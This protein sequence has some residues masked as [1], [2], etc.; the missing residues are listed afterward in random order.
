MFP[1]IWQRNK[2]TLTVRQLVIQS[3]ITGESYKGEGRVSEKP[4]MSVS[5]APLHIIFRGS[6]VAK[7]PNKTTF[8]NQTAGHSY[9]HSYSD[10]RFRLKTWS[11]DY[12]TLDIIVPCKLEQ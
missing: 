12:N 10:S 4:Q 6:H 7:K 11:V 3:G 8:S 2:L 1:S 5:S 9:T